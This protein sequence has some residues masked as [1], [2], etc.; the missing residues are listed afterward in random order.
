MNGVIRAAERMLDRYGETMA[1]VRAGQA[2]INVKARR[3]NEVGDPISG[4]M[5]D[6]VST[7]KIDNRAIAASAAPSQMPRKGDTIGGY[8]IAECDTRKVGETVAVHILHVGGG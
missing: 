8:I 4:T 7:I 3:Y 5:L 1:L 6:M 2:S